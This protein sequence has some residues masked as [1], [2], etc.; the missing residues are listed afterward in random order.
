MRLSPN[1]RL[2]CVVS[3]SSHSGNIVDRLATVRPLMWGL[4]LVGL[5]LF[6]A[7]NLPW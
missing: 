6:V 1:F 4:V 2:G 5:A 7:L 3:I